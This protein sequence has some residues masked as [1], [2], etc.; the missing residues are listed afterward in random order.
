MEIFNQL[1]FAIWSIVLFEI[2]QKSV[3]QKLNP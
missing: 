2:I 3:I 1:V